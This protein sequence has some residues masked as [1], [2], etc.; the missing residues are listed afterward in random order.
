[1][2]GDPVG[3]RVE[4]PGRRCRSG[5]GRGQLSGLGRWPVAGAVTGRG[6]VVAGA[7]SGG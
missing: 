6:V 2:F 3:V 7:A 5:V 1:M 4:D